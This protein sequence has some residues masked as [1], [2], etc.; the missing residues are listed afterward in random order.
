MLRCV[1]HGDCH[2]ATVQGGSVSQSVSCDLYRTEQVQS[3]SAP[4]E[5]WMSNRA[6]HF[7]GCCQLADNDIWTTT[8]TCTGRVTLMVGTHGWESQH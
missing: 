6:N 8:W 5:T 7:A 4:H 2:T 1:Q 3:S